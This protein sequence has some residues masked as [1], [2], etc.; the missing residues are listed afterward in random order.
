VVR[1]IDIDGS[2]NATTNGYGSP[3]DR[4]IRFG[5]P[6]RSAAAVNEEYRT[7]GSSLTVGKIR[8]DNFRIGG[9]EESVGDAEIGEFGA[10]DPTASSSRVRGSSVRKSTST[11]RKDGRPRRGNK[12]YRSS[13]TEYKS[14]IRKTPATTTIRNDHIDVSFYNSRQPSRV[15]NNND[16]DDYDDN[17]DSSYVV[18]PGQILPTEDVLSLNSLES[19]VFLSS[20]DLPQ[21]ENEKVEELPTL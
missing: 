10:R 13:E 9:D 21:T 4:L 14:R 8:P 11:T 19:A 20:Y 16:D 12:K 3:G 1:I 6:F 5:S 7:I 17:D 15:N 18:L 2:N